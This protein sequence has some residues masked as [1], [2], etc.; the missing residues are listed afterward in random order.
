[1][2][3]VARRLSVDVA[4]IYLPGVRGAASPEE[5]LIVFTPSGYPPRDEFTVA[6]ELMELHMPTPVAQLQPAERERF[7]DRGAAA[8]LLPRQQFLF[9][10][11]VARGELPELRRRWPWASWGAIAS[12]FVDLVPGTAAATWV[13][14]ERD[15][16]RYDDRLPVQAFVLAEIAAHDQVQDDRR[17]HALV[18]RD[19]ARARAWRLVARQGR[20]VTLTVTKTET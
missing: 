10:S 7:C 3:D 17:A 6:H 5:R 14:G 4:R 1:M 12:R 2:V 11:R 18:L 8:L 9:T 13:N 16:W 19:R 15:W 20:K